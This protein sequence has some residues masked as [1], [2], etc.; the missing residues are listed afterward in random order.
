M[1]S[2]SS[3][4]YSTGKKTNLDEGI[5]SVDPG[6]FVAATNSGSTL[7]DHSF[8]YIIYDPG[9]NGKVA[10]QWY[11]NGWVDLSAITSGGIDAGF[12]PVTWNSDL[13]TYMYNGEVVDFSNV[14]CLTQGNR[15]T[16][17]VFL[18]SDGT[19]Y[20]GSV[21]GYNNE[22]LKTARITDY[23]YAA[24]NTGS[25]VYNTANNTYE[26]FY[27][28]VTYDRQHYRFSG[29]SVQRYTRDVS[30]SYRT[31][32]ATEATDVNA[33]LEDYTIAQYQADME[34]LVRNDEALMHNDVKEG[35]LENISS[36][37]EAGATGTYTLY[38]NGIDGPVAIDGS[39]TFTSEGGTGGTDTSISVSDGTNS[40][41]LPTGSVV[42]GNPDVPAGTEPAKLNTISINGQYYD[43]AGNTYAI[44]PDGG[45]GP[46]GGNVV[47]TYTLQEYDANGDKTQNK[48]DIVDTDTD[49]KYEGK[50]EVASGSDY[51]D[52]SATFNITEEGKTAAVGDTLT[53]QAGENVKITE[54]NGVAEITAKDTTL[55]E[56]TTGLS[57]DANTNK[58]TLTVT[59]PADKSVTGEVDLSSLAENTKF[60]GKADVSG[61]SDYGQGSA[62]FNIT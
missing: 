50:A 53:I 30:Y 24:D 62:T 22:I 8:R 25:Y 13:G 57:L 4:I 18:K 38:R 32:W 28:D 35:K 47:K 31:F 7:A 52:G 58:L 21:Y 54:N 12:K 45:T 15:N 17:G 55:A 29:N 1:N 27:S 46:S 9:Y 61:G 40:V 48:W 5:N 44:D 23:N 20:T 42:K 6:V 3:I 16:V 41:K 14:Y 11:K 49:T 37:G 59:D 56:S 36:S 19:V 2:T 10:S 26:H 34:A 43:V 39:L 60:E 33:T 51:A